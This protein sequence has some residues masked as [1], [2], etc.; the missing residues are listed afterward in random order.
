MSDSTRVTKWLHSSHRKQQVFVANRVAEILDTTN[1]SQWKHVSDINN[2]ADFGTRAI[3]IEELKRSEW[4]TGP[5]GLKRPESEWPEQVNIIF[6]SDEENISPS[7]FMIQAEEKKTV[8]QWERFSNF[9][10]LVNTV[11]CKQRAL[12]KHKP[13]RL[14]TSKK[15]RKKTKATICNLLQR[16]QFG[17]Q[18]TFLKAEKEIPKGGSNLQFSPFL[19]EEGLI[20][21]KSRRGKSQL[22]FNGKHPILLHLKHPAVKLF[23]QNEHKDN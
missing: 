14:V 12:S 10:R 22:D 5:A 11:A 13:A 16:E 8:I 18:M 19:D 9:N 2:T 20:R 23:L 3:N 15:E 6:A 1:V 7:I 21:A 17:E 4:L